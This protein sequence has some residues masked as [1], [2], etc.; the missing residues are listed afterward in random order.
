MSL[1]VLRKMIAGA[2]AATWVLV[3]AIA[4]AQD[5]QADTAAETQGLGDIVVTATRSS[6]TVQ[7][8]PVAVT[9]V[10]GD[11]L[12]KLQITNA[13]D[14]GQLAPN[15]VI[16]SVTGGSAG[17]T[18]FIRGGAV[19]DGAN[20]TSEPEVGIYIDDVYQPRAAASF[21]EA[22]DLERVE[23]LR[24]P[25]GTLYGRNSSAGALKFVTRLPSETMSLK[26]ELGIGSW[27]E[28][29][30]RTSFSGPVSEDG[31]LRAG[32]SGMYRQRDGGRQ[33]NATLDRK[34]GA[35]DFK[36]FQGDLY[37]AGE[38]VTARLKGFYSNYSSDGLY[39]VALDPF[40]AGSDYL[41]VQPTSG[42]YR[43]VLSPSESYTKDEQFGGSLTINGE[44][45]DNWKLTS[46]TAYS[47]LQDDWAVEFSG[48]VPFTAFGVP[49]PGYAALFDR[50]SLSSQS[51]FSQELQLHGDMFDGLLTFLGGLYY[52]H[53][54]GDQVVDSSIFFTPSLA[55]YTIDTDSYAAF[56][57]VGV[58]V[59]DRITLSFGGRYTEDRKA[60]DATL[61]GTPVVRKDVFRDFLPKASIDFQATPGVLFYASYS[62]GFKAGGY[63][64]LASTPEQLGSPYSPQKVKAYE[65]GIKSEFLNRKARVNVSGFINEYSSIQQQYVNAAGDFLT[66]N[67]EATHKGVEAE[68]SLRPIPALTLWANA[69]YNDGVYKGAASAGNTTSFVGNAM[70]NVFKYQG[71]LGADLSV[72]A[73]P[74]R[75]VAGANYTAR[76]DYF[77]T[78][79]N[80]F[81]GHVPSTEIV[82]GYVGYELDKWTL[83]LT[84]KN[85]TDE[86]YWTTGFGFSVVRPRFMGDPRT[87]RLSLGYKF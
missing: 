17:I 50:E 14:I 54:A 78:P 26:A 32:F 42:S 65:V 33:Y 86:R 55:A 8:V 5:G 1:Q 23:V 66:E 49:V 81:I 9:A 27:D 6:S 36:G 59:D 75:F 3:P 71:T 11:T 2:A 43:T 87:W 85:L 41:A 31:R 10:S 18:P 61:N 80:S 74:G 68:L 21:V 46:I 39:P 58:H 83:R 4:Q 38:T 82:N 44:L 16:V 67:Y 15:V 7:K 51:A 53:E 13:K 19:T 73:G 48:G 63:N 35:E 40:Y 12:E 76:S 24:G 30:G 72:D 62:E 34:V 60:L 37:Y 79:D 25:Q 20:V 69:V 70:T 56:G 52:F 47:K 64:G 84:A 29:Y 22:L 57:Q 28:R 77:S 45:S